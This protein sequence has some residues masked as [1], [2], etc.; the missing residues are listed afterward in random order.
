MTGPARVV[1][2]LCAVALIAA[3]GLSSSARLLAWGAQGHHIVARIAWAEM[4]PAA[5]DRATAILG[6]G[7]DVFVA[8]ATWADEIRS[9]RPETSNWHFVDIP[10]GEAHYDAARDCKPTPNGDCLI[11]EIIRAQAALADPKRSA[12]AE[13]EPLKFLIHFVGDL[14]QPLH[15]IDDHDR[16]GNDV[17]VEALRGAEGRATNLHAA[18]DTGLINLSTE[19]EAARAA[20]LIDDLKTQPI[21]TTIDVVTW[22]EASHSLAERVAYHYPGFSPTGPPHGAVALDSAYRESAFATIDQQLER[23]GAR[24]AAVL[25]SILR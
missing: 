24:L 10:V 15:D 23:G 1:A 11:A 13:A 21:D 9:S 7:Q 6:G 12:E 18:W 20:R 16:G 4:T 22:A 19:T 14:H 2:C 5:R 25:N 17:H 3:L 8:T